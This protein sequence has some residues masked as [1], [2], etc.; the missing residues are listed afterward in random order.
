M[1]LGAGNATLADDCG[2]PPCYSFFD[3]AKTAVY[4]WTDTGFVFIGFAGLAVDDAVDVLWDG[5]AYVF[6]RNDSTAP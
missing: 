4:S 2:P 5:T 1:A 6:V 3:E